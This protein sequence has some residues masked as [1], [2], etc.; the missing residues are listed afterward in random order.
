MNK[1]I[2]SSIFAG[3]VMVTL[4]GAT[5]SYAQLGAGIVVG[6]IGIGL[7]V[8]PYTYDYGYTNRYWRT[9]YW[10]PGYYRYY[11]TTYYRSTY[12]RYPRYYRHNYY[13]PVRGGVDCFRG[14]CRS[15]Y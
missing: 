2:L 8:G 10:G 4:L 3:A 13:V 15:Y 5:P 12:Y 1:K 14:Y 6:P 7:G 11:P 9:N